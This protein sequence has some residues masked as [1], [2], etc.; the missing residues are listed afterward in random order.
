MGGAAAAGQGDASRG[1]RTVDSGVSSGE[2]AGGC[3]AFR[4]A[5]CTRAA[6]GA[7]VSG[8]PELAPAADAGTW[9]GVSTGGEYV[10][11]TEEALL[12]EPGDSGTH[13]SV[14]SK[15]ADF[16]SLAGVL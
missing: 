6:L 10:S 1:I 3:G 13:P 2:G 4:S 14:G 8:A 7:V 15:R 16:A 9:G 11:G 5:N 12:S